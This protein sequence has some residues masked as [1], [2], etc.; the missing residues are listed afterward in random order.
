MKFTTFFTYFIASMLFVAIL[1]PREKL[2]AQ[3]IPASYSAIKL[4]D[5]QIWLIDAQRRPVKLHSSAPR[6]TLEQLQ[7]NPAGTDKGIAFDFRIPDLQ[8]SLY[9]G[10][11]NF[12]D[13][14][15]PLPVYFKR[16]AKIENG[17]TQINIKD[18]MSG[19]YDMI[20]WEKSARGT[21]GFR[22]VDQRGNMLYDGRVSFTGTGPFAVAPSIIE[23]PF[24]NLLQSDGAAISFTTSQPVK[25]VVQINSATFGDAQKTAHHEIQVN[26]LQADTDY[27][28]IVKVAGFEQSYALH[29]A[30]QAGTRKPFV[31]AYASDSRNGRGGGE[32]NIYG[33]NAYIVKKIGALASQQGAAFIQFTGD[34]INGYL[35]DSREMDL[36][37]ANWKRAI[38]PFA[39]YF[40]VVAGMGNHEA[41]I[42]EFRDGKGNRYSV[43]KF[44]YDTYSAETAFA[45]NFVNPLNGPKG[46]DG[47]VYD[48]DPRSTDFPS[49]KENVFY[50][51]Y[52]NTAVVVLNSNYWYAPSLKYH[53]LTS[54]NLHGYIMDRQLKWLKE[55]LAKLQKNTAI[56]H[57]FITEHTPFFPNGGHVGDDMW[58]GG[59]NNPRAVVAGKPVQYGII[60]RRDQLLNLVVN[61]TPKVAAV[62]T[63]D[64]HNYCR[65]EIGPQTNIYPANY[66]KPKIQLQRTIWQINNGAAGAPYYAQEQTPWSDKVKGFTTQ[67]AVVFFHVNGKKIRM[68]VRNPDTLELVDEMELR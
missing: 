41:L 40:P 50:Y 65:T 34:L 31:F 27:N 51:T 67:N 18:K 60:E 23:G 58:Y 44:P 26:G 46:E 29:T 37:Y 42:Y 43:D 22:V 45:R 10:F 54:G 15:H 56:D 16:V 49:Y 61:Q 13:A 24:V 32:R 6:Y 4:I 53:T 63:G 17:K 7:G 11:I 33:A 55:T 8:G 21:L 25:A 35:H 28:Y 9:Y 64:E 20:G 2:C 48:P 19:K 12:T 57:I 39:H 62:L 68:E 52:D 47:A 66:D 5:G 38:E 14:R 3:Q 59:S 30:P 36:Q 1:S